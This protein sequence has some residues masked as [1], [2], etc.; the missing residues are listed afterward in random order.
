ML[1]TAVFTA[2]F[3]SLICIC[4]SARAVTINI[5]PGLELAANAPA[6]AAFNRAAAQWEQRLA[7]PI[8]VDIKADLTDLGAGIVA[9]TIVEVEFRLYNTDEGIRRA[10]ILDAADEPSNGIVSFLPTG[11]LL[12]VFLPDGFE[13]SSLFLQVPT[14]NLKALNVDLLEPHEFDGDIAINTV[15]VDF[16][17]DFDNSN[18]V[19]GLSVDFETV[20]AREIGHVLGFYTDAIFIDRVLAGL[21]D[22]LDGGVI[23]TPMDL[24]RFR[25]DHVASPPTNDAEFNSF[26]RSLHASN[27]EVFSDATNA[28]RL[29]AG[30]FDGDGNRSDTW[31]DNAL[32][33][34]NDPPIGIMDP[35]NVLSFLDE[36]GVT[37][38][39][40]AD[41]RVLDLIG[42]ELVPEPSSALLAMLA[43]AG[44]GL[45]S[46]RGR[47]K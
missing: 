40:D 14:A 36:S 25:D 16:G 37:E 46:R 35:S 11:D 2:M 7:D 6:L 10:L 32:V 13:P 1:R 38:I 30:E 9:D 39:S 24:F 27:Q 26:P 43:V 44:L 4:P 34:P 15:S 20:A 33:N 18:G 8:V 29:S 23:L 47:K 12:S 21:E 45:W 42:Y 41:L 28:W 19:D 3:A 22:I 5:V 17:F 31:K